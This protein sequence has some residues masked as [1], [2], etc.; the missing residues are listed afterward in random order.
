MK[1]E[2]IT[3][4]SIKLPQDD[5][6]VYL[7]IMDKLFGLNYNTEVFTPKLY[8]IRLAG[9][10]ILTEVVFVALRQREKKRFIAIA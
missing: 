5:A 6:V 9:D 1:C 10:E 2:L 4:S 7:S 3:F 8:E